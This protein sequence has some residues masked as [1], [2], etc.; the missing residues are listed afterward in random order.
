MILTP[1]TH[2][3][4]RSL[5]AGATVFKPLSST[6]KI[7]TMEAYLSGTSES[8]TISTQT[9]Q[10]Y[11]LRCGGIDGETVTASFLNKKS[12]LNF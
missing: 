3:P 12:F 1:I 5:D 2:R 10:P 11:I 6:L 7:K 4:R 9:G 8:V